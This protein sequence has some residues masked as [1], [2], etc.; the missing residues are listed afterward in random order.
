MAHLLICRI[1]EPNIM[2]YL[3]NKIIYF[4]STLV[5][6]VVIG[7]IFFLLK[8]IIP[9]KIPYELIWIPLYLIAVIIPYV[10]C[11]KYGLINV[12][13]KELEY[14]F[15][16]INKISLS[17]FPVIIRTKNR[18]M[19]LF[20]FF[21]I[22]FILN[23][24]FNI[25]KWNWITIPIIILPI[26]YG[27]FSII[28]NIVHSFK[29]LILNIEGVIIKSIKVKFIKWT[30]IDKIKIIKYKNT[31]Y[32]SDKNVFHVYNISG[33]LLGKCILDYGE[34]RDVLRLKKLL[35]KS[36]E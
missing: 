15:E 29:V 10:V 24:H 17:E 30:D 11:N 7:L 33:Q 31:I 34:K 4:G 2:K 20:L 3:K 35:I 14:R 6:V 8:S 26:I 22:I 13:I 28:Y 36:N 12:K 23:L 27:F 5:F 32:D 25:I 18:G 1:L 19:Y 21:S 16:G 9:N